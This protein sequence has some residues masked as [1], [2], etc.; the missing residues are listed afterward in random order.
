VQLHTGISDE[1]VAFKEEDK[2]LNFKREIKLKTISKGATA[3]W[4]F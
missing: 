2:I 1:I 4:N 3:Y